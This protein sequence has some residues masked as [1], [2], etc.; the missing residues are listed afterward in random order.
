MDV[1]AG[2]VGDRA[3]APVVELES[4]RP[5]GSRRQRAVAAAERLQLR[6][7]V[8]ADHVFVRAQPTALEAS[9]IEV[10]HPAGFLRKGGVADED[11][12]ALLPRLQRIVMQPTPDR[13]G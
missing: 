1:P 13:R 3:V 7:L 12:G 2:E 8:G 5:S 6:L 11:P 10:E 9:L 4:A